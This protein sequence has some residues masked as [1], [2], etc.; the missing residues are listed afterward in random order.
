MAS[1]LQFGLDIDEPRALGQP[2]CRARRRMRRRDETIP[3]PQVAFRRHQPLAGLQLRD[4][5]RAA[6]AADD[7][8][9]C[10]TPRQFRRCADMGG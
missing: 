7:A 8:N 4:Q 2:S 5:L 1:L 9:L 10:E 6:L 3:A